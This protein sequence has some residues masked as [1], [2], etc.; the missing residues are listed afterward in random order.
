VLASRRR[1]SPVN[2]TQI[3]H[4]VRLSRHSKRRRPLSLIITLAIA[5]R[6][7][8]HGA[9]E[10]RKITLVG[11]AH[12]HQESRA[13][14]ET[15]KAREE[16][17]DEKNVLRHLEAS[18]SEVAAC[19]RPTVSLVAVRPSRGSLGTSRA[20]RR[21]GAQPPTGLAPYGTKCTNLGVSSRLRL[22]GDEPEVV[23][24]SRHTRGTLS[25][26]VGY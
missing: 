16:P 7:P 18:T 21:F 25:M 19:A 6:H 11:A 3:G 22:T 5:R 17:G 10:F 1:A 14:H 2:E 8:L 26:R 23:E 20:T 24:Y 15:A 13:I 9:D 12:C 4:L